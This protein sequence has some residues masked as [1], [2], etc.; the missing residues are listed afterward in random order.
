MGF[1]GWNA[2]RRLLQRGIVPMVASALPSRYAPELSP[3]PIFLDITNEAS[4]EA[5]LHRHSPTAI[6]HAA[7]FSAPL[8]CEKD[9]ELAYRINAAGTRNILH[10]A[11]QFDIPLVF[12]STDLVFRG[13]KNAL[14]EGFYTES[15]APDACIVYGQTKIAAERLFQDH[16]FGKW[17][18]VR[19]ALM[20]GRQVEWANG[21]P[22]FAVNLLQSGKSTTLFT[23]QFRT[24]AYIPD[25]IDAILLLLS[26]EHYGKI[27]HCGGIERIDRASF[28]RRYCAIAGVETSGIIACAMDDV[29]EYTT[30]VEDVS[31]SSDMLLTTLSYTFWK[32]TSLESSF[33]AMVG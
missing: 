17:L 11:A 12:L 33:H 22:Q 31:L 27:Y 13:K 5:C 1:F 21:F 15:D 8:A 32:P 30:R 18:I 2:V 7:A 28:V 3:Q 10:Y 14:E 29:P 26:G 16:T 9:P 20:F 19:S 24:P 4:I 6:L 25:I 23:D